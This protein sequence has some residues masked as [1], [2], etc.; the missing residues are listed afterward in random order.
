MPPPIGREPRRPRDLLPLAVLAAILL[1]A[2]AGWLLFPLLQ[3]ALSY[4]DCIASGH[5]NCGQ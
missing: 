5:N 1:L 4:Q 3:H 2:L